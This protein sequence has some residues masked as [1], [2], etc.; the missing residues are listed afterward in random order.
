MTKICDN[1]RSIRVLKNL[2]QE[3][4]AESLGISQSAYG[5]LERGE[6]R[7]TWEK[8][9]RIANILGTSPFQVSTFT[10]DKPYRVTEDSELAVEATEIYIRQTKEINVL[11]EKVRM[12]ESMNKMLINQVQDKDEI[13][14]LLK[15]Q[16]KGSKK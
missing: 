6:T 12:L 16:V 8:L 7:I 11:K 14:E 1:I 4:V 2:S 3:Y 5:K 13:I 10:T 9:E 15:T